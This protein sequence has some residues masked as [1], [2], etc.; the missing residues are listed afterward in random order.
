MASSRKPLSYLCLLHL[1]NF[2]IHSGVYNPQTDAYA[3]KPLFLST[4]FMRAAAAAAAVD[5]VHVY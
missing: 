2:L 5:G 1:I 4:G 3:Q